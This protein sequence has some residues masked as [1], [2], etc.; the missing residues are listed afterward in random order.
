MKNKPRKKRSIKVEL[1]AEEIAF[2]ADETI[3][4]MPNE[5]YIKDICVDIQLGL[6]LTSKDIYVKDQELKPMLIIVILR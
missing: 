6:A 3:D 1:S 4:K 2:L 5:H